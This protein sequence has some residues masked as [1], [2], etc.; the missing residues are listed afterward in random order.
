[1]TS[2][3]IL[4]AF[5]CGFALVVVELDWVVVLL[6]DALVKVLAVT[7]EAALVIESKAFETKEEAL[8]NCELGVIISLAPLFY[9]VKSYLARE[10]R[11]ISKHSNEGNNRL[12]GYHADT[13]V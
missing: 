2:P 10:E 5:A 1:M 11:D 4:P 13:S 12:K 7:E 3:A 6:V 9:R 8:T